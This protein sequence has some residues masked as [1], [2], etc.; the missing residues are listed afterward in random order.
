MDKTNKNSYYGKFEEIITSLSQY[1]EKRVDESTYFQ[2]L[3]DYLRSTIYFD[4]ESRGTV[5]GVTYFAF[6]ANLIDLQTVEDVERMVDKGD[7]FA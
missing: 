3:D 2:Y 1:I 4:D 7:I 6:R 5:L